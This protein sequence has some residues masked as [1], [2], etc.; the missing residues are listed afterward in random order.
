MYWDMDAVEEPIAYK[1]LAATIMPRPIAWVVTQDQ[2]GRIN[3]APYSFFN[4]MGSEPPTVVLGIQSDTGRGFKDTAAN[5]H[6]TGEFVINLVPESMAP[7]MNIT[8]LDAPPGMNELDIAGLEAVPS[9]QVKP[10]RIKGSPVAFECVLHSS[11]VTG[12]YQTVVIGRVKAVHID[13]R[14]VLNKERAHIDTPALG[15]VG[16][17]Y[18]STYVRTQDSFDLVRPKWDSWTG[19]GKS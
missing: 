4:A 19:P 8:A 17:S 7:A 3:A 15:L 2:E 16:R 1:L 14:F 6:A 9:T 12:P 10:P 13:D 5:I 18:G 11:V